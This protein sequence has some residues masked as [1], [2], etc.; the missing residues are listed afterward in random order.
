M[1][2]N[3]TREKLTRIARKT[4]ELMPS[5]TSYSPLS[6]GRVKL[7]SLP[8]PNILEEQKQK[9]QTHLQINKGIQHK[10]KVCELQPFTKNNYSLPYDRQAEDFN[11]DLD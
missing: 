7:C 3:A 6:L 1:Q 4:V 10:G 5:A 8:D 2:I 9:T 11:R